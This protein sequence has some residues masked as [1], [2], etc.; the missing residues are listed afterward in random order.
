[1]R[2]LPGGGT[3]GSTFGLQEYVSQSDD[4]SEFVPHND[5]Y[6]FVDDLSVLEIINLIAVGLSSYNFKQHVASDVGIG[7]LF[8]PSENII[9]R[10]LWTTEWTDANKMKLN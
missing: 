2:E 4:N 1:M 6:K 10:N 5:K 9:P 7:Q 3:Q 8:I